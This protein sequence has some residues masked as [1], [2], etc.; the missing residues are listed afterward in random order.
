MIA[1]SGIMNVVIY[2]DVAKCKVQLRYTMV[3]IT[4]VVKYI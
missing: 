1:P 4:Y 2:K 3:I